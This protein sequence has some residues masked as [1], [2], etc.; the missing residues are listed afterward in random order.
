MAINRWSNRSIKATW[1]IDNCDDDEEEKVKFLMSSP[2]T[3]SSRFDNDN[4]EEI[5]KANSRNKLIDLLGAEYLLLLNDLDD[6]LKQH[7]RAF[8]ATRKTRVG[9]KPNK[10]RNRNLIYE[11]PEGDTFNDEENLYNYKKYHHIGT[12][13]WGEDS[14]NDISKKNEHK[15]RG[16]APILTIPKR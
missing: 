1:S 12:N 2:D 16:S 6:D 8:Q 14:W 4:K 13:N 11:E 5:R 10:K 15:R 9:P 3:F 7:K